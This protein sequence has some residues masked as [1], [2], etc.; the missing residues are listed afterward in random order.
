MSC[1]MGNVGGRE[2]EEW[3]KK[4]R[5]I[6]DSAALVFFNFKLSIMSLTTFKE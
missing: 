3:L 5:Q 1:I 6:S 2:E 4:K